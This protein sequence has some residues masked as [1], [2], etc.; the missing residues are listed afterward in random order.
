MSLLCLVHG[1]WQGAWCWDLLIPELEARGH[2]TVA[3]DLPIEDPSASLS[4]F[5]DVVL[6]ALVGADDDVV[7][8]GH[9][10]A[11]TVIPLVASQRPV[12]RLVFL[13]A[14]IPHVGTS[15]L[16]Q[17]YDEVDPDALKAAAYKPP[18]ASQFE[19]FRD[20][21]D[22]FNPA[23][24]GKDP[25]GS[26]ALAMELLFHDCE[27]DVARWA[28]S[29]Q[30][31]QQSMAHIFEVTPLQAFPDVQYTYIVCTDDRTISP[32]WSRYAARKRLG[33]DAIEL[34]GGHCPYLS[35]PTH[36][37]SVLSAE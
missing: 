11:G 18:E 19:Q 25:S 4:H 32:V 37:A 1:A 26:E 34:P 13:A 17:C 3:M 15:V 33:V 30:R 12:R 5:A 24:L 10:M 28:I 29:K 16:D 35:R 31:N 14:L 7:L 22:M 2:K 36:L 21:P 6:Q 8:I 23:A 20:E 27:P 9:S